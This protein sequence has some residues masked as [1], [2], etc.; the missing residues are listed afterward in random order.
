MSSEI[1]K[2][3]EQLQGEI[4]EEE[5]ATFSEVVIDHSMN[6]RNLG[7]IEEPDGYAK[8]TGICGDTMEIY[9][10]IKDGKIVTCNFLTDGCGPSI[11]CGSIV[12]EL[13]SEKSII[14]A[15]GITQETVL[16]TCNGL[17]E[18]H[19]HCAL[20][21]SYTLNEAIK[22]Y[23]TLKRQPWKKSYRKLYKK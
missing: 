11:A 20:L 8:I 18:S 19:S 12:T 16:K 3:A 4:S 22:E 17:P 14:E 5:K 15:K 13:A 23:E 7:A 10:R 21:A 1:D 6:P 2:F 9:L